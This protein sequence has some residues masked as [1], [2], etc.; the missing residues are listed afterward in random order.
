MNTS[1]FETVVLFIFSLNLFV[2]VVSGCISWAI[3]K[4]TKG[5]L[6]YMHITSEKKNNYQLW[7][8]SLS[9]K[10]WYYCLHP[11]AETNIRF[12]LNNT[13]YYY[14]L[15]II[16]FNLR[17]KTCIASEV[18][19]RQIFIEKSFVQQISKSSLNFCDSQKDE[20]FHANCIFCWSLFRPDYVTAPN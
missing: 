15:I 6:N 4:T 20:I 10:A 19:N 9:V 12:I 17:I 3:I 5:N 7:F 2:A 16:F 1:T 14:D 8:R 18:S 13:H 11:L